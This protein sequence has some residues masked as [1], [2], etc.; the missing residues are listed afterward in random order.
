MLKHK[1]MKKAR[2][3]WASA[4]VFAPGKDITP[5]SSVNC[6]EINVGTVPF[7]Y[8][9][10]RMNDSLDL[11]GVAIIFCKLHTQNGYLEIEIAIG[12]GEKTALA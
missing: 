10:P 11:L 5:Q 7:L 1:F 8:I 3:K 2:T 9:I 4:M 12:D 6:R